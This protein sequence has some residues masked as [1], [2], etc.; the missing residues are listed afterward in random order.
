MLLAAGQR[1][2][3][4]EI[5]RPLGVGGM[6][7]VYQARD[8]RLD[9]EVAIKV[10]PEDCASMPER[11]AR[12]HREAKLASKLSHANIA[13]IFEAG[14]ADGLHFIAMELIRGETLAQK[15]SSGKMQARE[16]LR[17]AQALAEGLDEAHRAGVVHRDL[18]PANVMVDERGRVKIL[19]F[20]LCREESADGVDL[21]GLTAT[22][23]V[24]GTPHYMSPEQARAEELDARSDLFS[25]G[26]ILY[27]LATGV[28]PFEGDSLAVVLGAVLEGE[29]PSLM[30]VN[31][32]V[33]E[34][35]AGV[36]E[37]LLEKDS[38]R[39][40]QSAS[41]LAAE[42]RRRGDRGGKSAPSTGRPVRLIAAA[43]AVV[44]LALV[45]V[46]VSTYSAGSTRRKLV[47]LP[48]DTI[49][50][51]E[52]AVVAEAITEAIRG[53]LELVPE[54]AVIYRTSAARYRDSA[55]TI[56]EIG[57][58][59]G[60]DYVLAGSVTWNR[61]QADQ[62]LVQP[63]LVRVSDEATMWNQSYDRV[64]DDL[65]AIQS[66]I[67]EQVLRELSVTLNEEA[68]GFEV[69]PTTNQEA[70]NAYV[71]GKDNADHPDPYIEEDTRI[72]VQMFERAVGLDSGFALAWAE[73]SWS[74][75]VLYIW[76]HDRTAER[77]AQVKDTAERALL[78]EPD[79][80]DAHVALGYYYQCLLDYESALAE[81]QEAGR[82]RP[83]DVRSLAAEAGALSRLG[84]FDE[85]AEKFQ[86]AGEK[87]PKDSYLLHEH[88]DVFLVP[89][90][91]EDAERYYD[92]SISLAPD[93]VLAYACQAENYWLQG[94]VEGAREVLAGMPRRTDP[95][96]IR[97]LFRT[98][99]FAEDYEGALQELAAAQYEILK[100]PFWYKPKALYAAEAYGLM[101]REGEAQEAYG[102][103]LRLLEPDAEQNPGD[104]RIQS[105]LAQTYAGLGRDEDAVRQA[106]LVTE[107]V[108]IAVD[109][110]DGPRRRTDLAAVYAKTGRLDEAIDEIEYL[111]TIPS[112]L[113]PEI[114]R[115]DPRWRNVR[116]HPRLQ[117][118]LERHP[119]GS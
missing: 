31:P 67:A 100:G 21:T 98:K 77:L 16:V 104:S 7:E 108:P 109:K 4:Y 74:H 39:R 81:F 54:L 65:F 101:G 115:L 71:R 106:L 40:F 79:L 30:R 53:R 116:D 24:L 52:E 25:L 9:R 36:V 117:A 91:Y 64:I 29:P 112:F 34:G 66:E 72:A 15:I 49:G 55:K 113:T 90:R 62:M 22:G 61:G 45:V 42:L 5:Q 47:V 58:E 70:W 118:I 14:E 6:G 32:H 17:I 68:I 87:N 73:L 76:G 103:A 48:F 51:A 19:D 63:R 93:Q 111:L 35:F 28:R 84:R 95:R 94:N 18:K 10:L 2:S 1:L 69:L 119:S 43:V 105:A 59:L 41:D 80:P 89:R 26:V 82:L 96:S 20:G 8:T 92:R 27:E 75:A 99:L 97:I 86:E 57:N 107:L 11:V 37:R 88:G 44:V 12:F 38:T 50:P 102:L 83:G 46:F 13:T 33:G 78:L 56:G 3:V 60:V 23:Q 110:I 85:S 114:L